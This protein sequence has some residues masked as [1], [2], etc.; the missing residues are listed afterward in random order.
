[1]TMW[2]PLSGT[3]LGLDH[4]LFNREVFDEFFESER[5]LGRF[6]EHDEDHFDLELAVT[7]R[8][9]RVA[10]L[11]DSGVV[12][13]GMPLSEFVT[14]MN[15]AFRKAQIS[16]GGEIRY[17]EI[18]LGAVDIDPEDDDLVLKELADGTLSLVSAETPDEAEAEGDSSSEKAEEAVEEEELPANPMLVISDLALAEVPAV[19]AASRAAIAVF[20]H[21][22]TRALVAS[23][24]VD[25]KKAVFPKP[26]FVLTLTMVE[27]KPVLSVQIDNKK[28]MVWDWSGEH[29]VL[30]WMVDEQAAMDFAEEH[31]GAGAVARTCVL[32]IEN[33]SAVDVRQALLATP[34]LGPAFF[35]QAM[36]L[37]PEVT[38]VL[39]GQLP[40]SKLPDAQVFE[41]TS[42]AQTLRETV[43]LEISGQGVAAPGLW[44]AYR[45][46]Y[47]DHPA[48]MNA[49]ASVQAG[50][51]GTIF[52][53]S[54]KSG[55]SKKAKWGA[56]L[57]AF[58]MINAVSRVVTTQWVQ[59]AMDRSE[60]AK[61]L[62]DLSAQA[63][64][65]QAQSEEPIDE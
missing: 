41:S 48:L 11:D 53:M 47:L 14:A 27:G 20:P 34:K 26:V 54:L 1:M 16:I 5:V 19:A 3:I 65:R 35:V 63:R 36:K 10:L 44:R 62:L 7:G 25:V 39:Y 43:A 37:P 32:D 52:A 22:N 15:E 57:G 38:D 64:A 6:V 46:A 8:K 23:K 42:F 58:L 12:I 18:D 24:N 29:D 9:R 50:I 13:P 61:R 56:G 55:A 17:G 59:Q 31:L 4:D 45:K 21:Y 49:V 33:A 28:P 40:V 51:G 30:D 2:R 60:S